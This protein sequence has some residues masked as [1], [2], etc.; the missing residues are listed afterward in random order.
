[1][2]DQL[3]EFSL[4][5]GCLTLP[6]SSIMPCFPAAAAHSEAH[7]LGI[8][9]SLCS[10]RACRTVGH[11]R[12][13]SPVAGKVGMR[14]GLEAVCR[15][16]AARAGYRK[17]PETVKLPATPP[18]RIERCAAILCG[19]H[20]RLT[21]HLPHLYDSVTRPCALRFRRGCALLVL[22]C[23]A[24]DPGIGG[25]FCYWPLRVACRA[26]AGTGDRESFVGVGSVD[27]TSTGSHGGS[28]NRVAPAVVLEFGCSFLELG[29]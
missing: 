17:P 10:D 27:W 20:V 1:M 11:A 8:R 21:G 23:F 22:A 29:I 14:R 18:V 26:D 16:D 15:H 6:P 28:A 7:A 4:Q 25:C 2:P 19:I 3:G 5:K 24:H 12:P 13:P 9:P